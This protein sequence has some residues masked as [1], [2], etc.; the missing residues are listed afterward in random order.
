MLSKL[1][2]AQEPEFRLGL[3]ELEHASGGSNSDIRLS[4]EIMQQV[5]EKIRDL[6]LDPTDTT[7]EELYAVLR[8]RLTGDESRF[9]ELLGLSADSSTPEILAATLKFAQDLDIPRECFAIKLS[10]GKT[11]LKGL[12]PKKVMKELGYRSIESMIKHEPVPQLLAAALM[13]ESTHWQQLFYEQYKKLH[14]T[15]FEQR[16]IAIYYP[17]SRKWEAIASEFAQRYKNTTLLLPEFGSIIIMPITDLVPNL[18]ITSTLLLLSQVNDIRC[19]S[20]FIKLQQVRPDFGN[21]LYTSAYGKVNAIAQLAGQ[22]L[23]WK[24][25]HNYYSR[26]QASELPEVF[27]PHVQPEDLQL[28]NAEKILAEKIPS[29]EFWVDTAKLALVSDTNTVSLNMLDVALNATNRLD[30]KDSILKFVQ[31]RV[32]NEILIKYLNPRNLEDVLGQLGEGLAQQPR[33]LSPVTEMVTA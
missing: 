33:E 4:A 8:Q 7:A 5:N 6:G 3:R 32:W 26:Q 15:N 9:R 25:I 20:S 28:V 18:A 29:L 17:Q 24:T 13:Y 2:S 27:D 16:S 23:S 11:L 31:D 1:L 30:F 19:N 14:P 10:V 21:I 12:P 22:P